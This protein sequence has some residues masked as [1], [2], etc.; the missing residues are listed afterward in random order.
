LGPLFTATTLVFALSGVSSYFTPKK[1]MVWTIISARVKN[2]AIHLDDNNDAVPPP[3]TRSV[4]TA[5]SL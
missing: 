4:G 1:F 2:D 5:R 3:P